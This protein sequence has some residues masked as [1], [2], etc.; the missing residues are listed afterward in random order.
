MPNTGPPEAYT[1]G[2]GL[3]KKPDPCADKGADRQ[4]CR[5]GGFS[6][7]FGT[8]RTGHAEGPTMTFLPCISLL[9]PVTPDQDSDRRACGAD[10]SGSGRCNH[11]RLSLSEV[12]GNSQSPPPPIRGARGDGPG[13]GTLHCTRTITAE[14]MGLITPANMIFDGSAAASSATGHPC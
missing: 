12:T 8:R 6:S 13:R 4:E 3:Q 7:L 5:P 11:G 2:V 14:A 10:K 1:G 9:S